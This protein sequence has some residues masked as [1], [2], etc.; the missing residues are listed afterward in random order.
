LLWNYTKN[1]CL[2]SV[3]TNLSFC[4][5]Q[6]V[7][8]SILSFQRHPSCWRSKHEYWTEGRELYDG[9]HNNWNANWVWK[10]MQEQDQRQSAKTGRKQHEV[11]RVNFF[12][13]DGFNCV[14]T[15]MAPIQS[16]ILGDW[17]YFE[18][19]KKAATQ[20]WKTEQSDKR[21]NRDHKQRWFR[22]YI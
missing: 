22:F 7:S 16:Q 19:Y 10:S 11:W 6:L 17:R 13:V 4:I 12:W 21:D 1:I 5:V 8:E 20:G 15:A 14:I 2:H 18:G 9:L 3:T